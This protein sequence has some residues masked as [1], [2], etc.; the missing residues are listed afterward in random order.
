MGAIVLS[1]LQ[2]NF[3]HYII[4]SRIFAL[5]QTL[6]LNKPVLRIAPKENYVIHSKK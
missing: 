4:H 5:N 2:E 1:I 6:V 3:T